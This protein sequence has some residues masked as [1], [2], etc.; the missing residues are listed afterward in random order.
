MDPAVPVIASIG[1]L[2][3]E[4][5]TLPKHQKSGFVASLPKPFLAHELISTLKA[6]ISDK[7][8]E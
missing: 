8:T 2:A 3:S 5:M 7:T 6:V 1:Y 4:D